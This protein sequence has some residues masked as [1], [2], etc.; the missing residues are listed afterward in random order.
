MSDKY[1]EQAKKI[2]YDV[3]FSQCDADLPD[4]VAIEIIA[5]A[6]LE[7]GQ[8]IE[9]LTEALIGLGCEYRDGVFINP[10]REIADLRAEN[11][12]LQ[13]EKPD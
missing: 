13:T 12:R 3:I 2:F 9:H 8:L 5:A 1:D 10:Q 7:Q 4:K 11:E 6:L